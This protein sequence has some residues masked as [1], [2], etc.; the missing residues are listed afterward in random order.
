MTKKK[1]VIP[2]FKENYLAMMEKSLGTKMFQDCY[3]RV[4]GKKENITRKGETSCAY[5]V[6]SILMVFGLI[7]EIHLT[8]KGTI[9][10]IEKFGWRRIK[11][12]R[13]GSILVWEEK[14]FK[15]E[16]HSHLGFFIGR[17]KA[18][19]RGSEKRVP[20]VHAWNFNGKRKV[21]AIFWHRKLDGK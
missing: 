13:K 12:P 20:V 4:D 5:F 3:A 9:K 16:K 7:K 15:D 2:L 11:R 18:I 1:K 14:D 21:E 6:S 19:S 17:A 10:D 8:V